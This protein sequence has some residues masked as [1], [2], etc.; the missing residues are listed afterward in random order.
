M[1]KFLIDNK[2]L[3]GILLQKMGKGNR[4]SKMRDLFSFLVGR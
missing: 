1:E 2:S 3:I 4:V